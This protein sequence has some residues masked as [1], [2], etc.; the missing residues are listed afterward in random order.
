[1]RRFRSAGPT[2]GKIQVIDF[3]FLPGIHVDV[4]GLGCHHSTRHVMLLDSLVRETC[5]SRAAGV[6]FTWKG[7]TPI[8][9]LKDLR[10]PH[11]AGAGKYSNLSS[12]FSLIEEQCLTCRLDSLRPSVTRVAFCGNT[13]EY[14][15]SADGTF[16]GLILNEIRNAMDTNEHANGRLGI[17]QTDF[18]VMNSDRT[19]E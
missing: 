10:V 18:V 11:S 15:S 4:F 5:F 1:L 7:Q 8:D 16:H 12:G 3:S 14:S 6:D 17:C 2:N 9:K 19:G 13:T